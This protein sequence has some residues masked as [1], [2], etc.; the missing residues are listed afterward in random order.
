MGA[1][2]DQ[3][4]L[5]LCSDPAPILGVTYDLDQYL[6]KIKS[7]KQVLFEEISMILEHEELS[8]GQAGKLR[9]KLMFGA[10][11]LW[12]K[13]DRAFLKALSDRQYS[14]RTAS[15][16]LSPASIYALY[17]WKTL[18]MHR[19]PRPIPSSGPKK[20]DVLIFTD[21][22]APSSSPKDPPTE[23]IGGVMFT[24]DD[25][26]RQF[27]SGVSPLIMQPWFP[28]KPRPAW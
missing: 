5:Q 23:M 28:R 6:L 17:K 14:R 2:F 16:G 27:S 4:K 7:R 8:P 1:R 9:E 25:P 13:I 12:G 3:Q 24:R 20:S 22:S 10:S 21:G 19:L 26:P 11:Q 15:T 18:V